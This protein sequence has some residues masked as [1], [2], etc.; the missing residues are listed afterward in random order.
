MSVQP[1][2]NKKISMSGKNK[3]KGRKARRK[4]PIPRKS[5][6]DL[7]VQQRKDQKPIESGAVLSVRDGIA[8]IVGLSHVKAGELVTFVGGVKGMIL[9][10]GRLRCSAVILGNDKEIVATSSCKRTFNVV[11]IPV[12]RSFLGRVID[13]LGNP[14][15]GKGAIIAEQRNVVDV[16]APGIIPRFSIFQP[17][18][19]GLLAIDSMVPVGRG[20]RE[21]IIGDRQT[22][23]TAIAIDTI[24]NQRGLQQKW[25]E[26][27]FCVY[28]AIG[29]KRST[30][31]QVVTQLEKKGALAYTA[32]VAATAS[33]NASLQFLA[34][35]SGCALAE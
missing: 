12:G 26:S 14:I 13:S 8:D 27:V 7:L 20:Q 6:W 17:L 24:I 33:D 25:W 30:V 3:T 2:K 15:D 1:A 29:Q 28:V 32:I 9:N 35:Y 31:A 10:L 16:K 23:K 18:Q 4:A 11:T 34:P 5:A 19:T 21:L 22:G